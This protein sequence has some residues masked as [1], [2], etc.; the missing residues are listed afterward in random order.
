MRILIFVLALAAPLPALALSCVRP[1]VERTY[2]RAQKSPDAYVVVYGRLTTDGRKMPRADKSSQ[3]APKM[4]R[5]P[6]MI[7]G[8]SLSKSGFRT[9]FDQNITLE[10]AC[11]GPWCGSVG[12]STEVL[13]FIKRGKNGYTLEIDPCGGNVFASPKP[14]MLKQAQRCMRGQC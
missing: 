2:D 10:V 13:A 1:S 3:K 11:F 8:Q 6:A 4:T 7:S 9:P 12:N 14:A 5:I